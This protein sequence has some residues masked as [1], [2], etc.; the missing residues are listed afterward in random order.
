M[1][2]ARE[3]AAAALKVLEDYMAAFNARD[4]EAFEATINH[5]HVSLG[6][7]APVVTERGR[8]I[9]AWAA[10]DPASDWS[11]STLDRRAVIHA[12]AAKVH[13]D[14]R[15]TRFRRD[16]SVIGTYDVLY[17]VTLENGRW[18]MKALSGL[19]TPGPVD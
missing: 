19:E 4:F 15:I 9:P 5:P 14:A 1:P 17:V 18:G 13:I 16:G 6:A 2:S 10:T 8:P 7:G 11:H 12:G 3:V